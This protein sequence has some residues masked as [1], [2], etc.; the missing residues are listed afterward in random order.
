MGDLGFGD[1]RRAAGAPALRGGDLAGVGGAFEGVGTF[2]L[3]G[4]CQQYDSQLCHR[5][6]RVARVDADRIGEVPHSD[7]AF[8]Q[9]V[10]QV[11]GVA[12][13]PAEPV[14]G[15]RGFDTTFRDYLVRRCE[16]G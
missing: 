4:Q 15:V 12:H 2:H 10:D 1:H 6:V 7:S 16:L 14:E 8:A 5:A 13:V 3:R 11:Q 9:I